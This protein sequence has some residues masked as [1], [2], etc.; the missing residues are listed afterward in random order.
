MASAA[1]TGQASRVRRHYA[2]L[3]RCG[4]GTY[5]AGYTVDPV[6]RLA[7]HRG[8]PASRYTRGR[9]PFQLAA[10]WRCPTRR[11]AMILERMLKRL[12]RAAKARLASGHPIGRLMAG[13]VQL[14]VRRQMM[15]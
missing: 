7:A 1:P 13:A 2:Y 14:G 12:P 6:A 11:A 9:G 5:Y 10:V 3:L 4:D 15:C 8:G